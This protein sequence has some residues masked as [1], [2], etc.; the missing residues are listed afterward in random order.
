MT[1]F[2]AA[3]LLLWLTPPFGQAQQADEKSYL[4]GLSLD[5]L[6]NI[7]ITIASKTEETT[8]DAPS[9]VTVISRS[10]IEKMGVSTLQELLNFVP[11]FQ[12][13]SDI[14]NGQV[15][16]TQI[17]GRS[18]ADISNDVLLL[19]DG[20]RI[21]TS[22][23]GGPN[24]FSRLMTLG[25]IK[26]VEIIRG[27]GSA[28]YG[29]NAFLGVVNVVTDPDLREVSARIGENNHREASL[30][31]SDTWRDTQISLFAS[32]FADDGQ[33]YQ[34]LSDEDGPT[35]P[36][37]DPREGLDLYAR[38]SYRKLKVN[39][40]YQERRF[41]DFFVFNLLGNGQN[42]DTTWQTSTD[43]E[44]T[45]VENDRLKLNLTGSH[46]KHRWR[47]IAQFAPSPPLPQPWRFGPDFI[48]YDTNLGA[49]LRYRLSDRHNLIAG[50]F[51]RDTE[52]D[53]VDNVSNYVL[54]DDGASQIIPLFDMPT[55]QLEN[56][57]LINSVEA[58]KGRV[59]KGFYFQ[60]KI[61]FND[62]TTLFIGGRYDNYSDL[63]GRND[64]FNPRGGLIFTTNFDAKIKALYGSAFR[65]PSISELH[66]ISPVTEP[67]P[68]LKP[69]EVD[70]YELGYIQ[71]FRSGRRGRL[72]ATLFH[73]V[74][75][76]VIVSVPKGASVGRVN[77]GS[78][79]FTG[80]E[81]EL[82]LAFGDNVVAR[83]SYTNIF[84]AEV[85]DPNAGFN[86]GD[87]DT[88]TF[89]EYGAISLNYHRAAWNANFS[90]L[91][92]GRVK[93]LETQDPYFLAFARFRYDIT[94]SL[95]LDIMAKNLFDEDYFTFGPTAVNQSVH[96]RGR[97]ASI[98]IK[99]FY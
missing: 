43:V 56:Y 16:V 66:Q 26:Q 53:Q 86:P 94:S 50:V 18:N 38:L 60:D 48:N 44:Y 9:S 14:R 47:A 17:R 52:N 7:E 13:T 34:V 4:S 30:A 40:R 5:A 10:E 99:F 42:F 63:Q 39:A 69:E 6:F 71:N 81:L 3:A 84:M 41:E 1:F 28:L 20:Q 51:Y 23:D 65:A 74:I 85:D 36:T 24:I 31:Y 93:E 61:V 88:T 22:H 11:G 15:A 76:N 59:V 27:P 87:G 21:N 83:T 55:D 90:A 79:E 77:Q 89:Q 54:T 92:R 8:A 97:E 70:T 98:G 68:E 45:L 82:S 67:N 19:I 78:S 58:E 64:T 33:D 25:N 37:T 75:D 29:S 73:N 46:I 91:Y 35:M 2:R 96:N 72:E 12:N 95:T 62:R 57:T 49:N 32:A 80:V